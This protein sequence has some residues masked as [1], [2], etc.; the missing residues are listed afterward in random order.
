MLTIKDILEA[1]LGKLLNGK[2]NTKPRNYEFDSREVREGTFYIPIKGKNKDGHNYI[3]E[4][5]KKGASGFLIQKDFKDKEKTIK[6]SILL[7]KEIIIIEVENV[8]KSFFLM[9]QKNRE[10]HI[11][12]PI[13]AI[14]GSVGKTSTR[15]IIASVLEEKFSVLKTEK[16]YNNHLGIP[17]MLLKIDKQQVCVIEIGINRVGEM[18]SL[19]NLVKPDIVVITN[20]GLSHIENFKS[21]ETTYNEKIKICEKLKAGGFCIVNADDER[22]F[23]IKEKPDIKI[24]KYGI[25]NDEEYIV[26]NIN[27][28]E[29][30]ISFD[31]IDNNKAINVKINDIGNHNVLNAMAAI[32]VGKLFDLSIKE[33][34]KG[35]AKYRN[36]DQRMKKEKMANECVL[37]NDAYNASYDSVIS[38]LNTIEKLSANKKI[39]IIGDLL[40]LGKYS[41]TTH[42]K[43]GKKINSMNINTII[44]YGIKSEDIYKEITRKTINKYKTSNMEELL[45]IAYKEIEKGS[46]IYIKASNGMK[47][48]EISEKLLRNKTKY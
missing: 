23:K 8:E 40:E 5:I 22:L 17:F 10:K 6:E 16:N 45:K 4:C 36:F 21:L 28:A 35:I 48:Y 33:I 46:L 24:V 9:G 25:K 13:V 38:G 43:I 31:I 2:Q 19:S 37:I 7:N 30:K 44:T 18:E 15:E 32:K 42:S 27:L 12:T 47:L 41:K 34:L 14:T 26:D 11:T 20:V 1:S 29:E 3:L 39:L